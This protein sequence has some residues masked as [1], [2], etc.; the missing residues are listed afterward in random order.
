MTQVD[1]ATDQIVWEGGNR[2]VEVMRCLEE[3]EV[4]G[5]WQMTE[6][7]DGCLESVEEFED[8]TSMLLAVQAVG[9][10]G[11]WRA[12]PLEWRDD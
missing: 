10:L 9:S 5:G 2:R 6:Y 7:I 4:L 11:Q 3:P 1:W 12:E 8:A